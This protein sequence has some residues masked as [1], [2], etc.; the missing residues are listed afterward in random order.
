M[1]S[2]ENHR[3]QQLGVKEHLQQVLG[4][5]EQPKQE[6]RLL[7]QQVSSSQS[8]A[9]PIQ[10]VLLTHLLP[11]LPEDGL[12]ATVIYAIFHR[13]L[14]TLSTLHK[15]SVFHNNITSDKVVIHLPE[16]SSP[17]SSFRAQELEIHLLTFPTSYLSPSPITSQESVPDATALLKLIYDLTQLHDYF[18]HKAIDEALWAPINN[19]VVDR[20]PPYI[21]RLADDL[22]W[23]MW[24][25]C[26]LGHAMWVWN[27]YLMAMLGFF[28]GFR[29]GNSVREIEHMARYSRLE[30]LPMWLVQM[31]SKT[32]KTSSVADYM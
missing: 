14:I 9:T 19:P 27:D 6:E 20:G 15:H 3:E 24:Y 32:D 21:A 8:S 29:D 10:G 4:R 11:N 7:L 13:L 31:V 18:I 25:P 23:Q 5:L 22:K 1:V 12:P 17:R 30:T 16:G 28:D 26:T 2:N